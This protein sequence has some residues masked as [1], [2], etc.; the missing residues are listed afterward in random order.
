MDQWLLWQ[1]RLPRW[2]KGKR[3]HCSRVAMATLIL[4]ASFEDKN[5]TLP[6]YKEVPG[7]PQGSLHFR[8]SWNKSRSPGP[9]VDFTDFFRD[10]KA[11]T[12]LWEEGSIWK[13]LNSLKKHLLREPCGRD[14]VAVTRKTQALFLNEEARRLSISTRLLL[15]V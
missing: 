15:E 2:R 14:T 9:T 10:R 11:S 8:A 4:E 3:Q 7:I 6:T 13:P 5:H 1:P 12:F